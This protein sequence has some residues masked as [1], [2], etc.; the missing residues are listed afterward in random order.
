[1]SLRL[2]VL[3]R[4]IFIWGIGLILS[5][6]IKSQLWGVAVVYLGFAI[7]ANFRVTIAEWR[8]ARQWKE[9][10]RATSAMWNQF[11]RES[12]RRGLRPVTEYEELL[13]KIPKSPSLMLPEAHSKPI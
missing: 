5:C 8:W 1:M 9:W 2:K 12:A 3:N 13:N 7:Y 11:C 4:T 6:F 10:K